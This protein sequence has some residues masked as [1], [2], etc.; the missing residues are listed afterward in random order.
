[1]FQLNLVVTEQCNL[2]CKYCYMHNNPKIMTK[3]VVDKTILYIDSIIKKFNKNRYAIIYFGGEPLLNLDIIKYT[4][5]I[6]K[7][8]N[9]APNELIISNLL[10]LN[11]DILDWILHENINVSW[12]FD[13]LWN[14]NNRVLASDGSSS[15]EK[16]ISKIDIIRKLT[17]GSKVMI[18]PASVSTMLENAKFMYE[19]LKLSTLD[20]S[21]V[22]DDIWTDSDIGAFAENISKLAEYYIDCI[23][24]NKD[25]SIGLFTLP[26]LDM[27]VNTKY[28]K[29][30]FGCFAGNSGLAVMPNG[31]LYPCAR[32]GSNGR[33]KYGSIYKF[34]NIDFNEVNN[35]INMNPIEIEECKS[36][37]LY[38]YC[39]AGCTYSQVFNQK[40]PIKN[41]CKLYKII[42]KESLNIF[43]HFSKSGNNVYTNRIVSAL[44][45]IG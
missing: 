19:E 25:I 27:I 43:N 6:V 35:K 38:K 21:I 32:F 9:S 31:D 10:R 26:I 41:V 28:G 37:E 40:K 12:S 44:N 8:T 15:L 20:F 5:D 1:M 42:Y 34:D 4:H 39:N 17:K 2:A 11:E 29:R 22:R 30:P 36:C 23:E 33:Y 16:Y 3:D 7:T 45:N 18:S 24:H 14:E 13:G